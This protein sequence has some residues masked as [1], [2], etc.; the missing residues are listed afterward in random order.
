MLSSVLKSKRAIH[1]NIQIMRA[2]VKIRQ[3]LS[4]QSEISRGIKEINKRTIA[5]SERIRKHDNRLHF[6]DVVVE[7]LAKD[8]NKLNKLLP[9]TETN[10]DIKIGFYDRKKER[11]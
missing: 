8:V 9:Y 10:K 7:T 1:V 11:K 5:N 4:A 2:F 6:L 3:L